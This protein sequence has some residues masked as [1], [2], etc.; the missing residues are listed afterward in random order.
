MGY[1]IDLLGL[2]AVIAITAV[3]GFIVLSGLVASV[4]KRIKKLVAGS[5]DV[6]AIVF[7]VCILFAIAEF[8]GWL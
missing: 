3:V 5:A 2:P 8:M 4:S 7:I 1:L 6:I